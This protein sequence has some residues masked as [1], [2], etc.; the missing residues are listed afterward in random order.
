MKKSLLVIILLSIVSFSSGQEKDALKKFIQKNKENS[1][2]EIMFVSI[3]ELID[4]PDKYDGKVVRVRGFL[5]LDFEGT[6]IYVKKS[7]YEKHN[8]KNSIWISLSGRD[9]GLLKNQCN[10]KFA[11]IIG[12]FKSKKNGHFDLFSGSLVSIM[13]IDPVK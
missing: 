1:S 13:R 8:Y 6:A 11:S 9:R 10:N 2:G 3:K 12:T 5:V 4:H 7:D